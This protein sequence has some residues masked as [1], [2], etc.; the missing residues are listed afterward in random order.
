MQEP[1]R[2]EIERYLKAAIGQDTRILNLTLLGES[3]GKDIKEYGY[4]TPIQIDYQHDGKKQRAVLHTICP[5]P[6]GHE[7]MADRAQMALWDYHAV[8]L[9]PRH[10]R[11]ID[12]GAFRRNGIAV[13]LGDAEEFFVLTE[14]AE[15]R[16]YVEDVT[17][18]RDDCNLTELDI[19][20]ADALCDYLA[21]IHR[22][23]GDNPELYVRRIREL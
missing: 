17:R 12:A 10:V 4:G 22:L 15:G 14:Y 1:S 19:A 6:F 23:K 7:H 20:R 18:M 2:L 13:A 11:A 16:C 21:E 5:G 3:E 9:L 8:N